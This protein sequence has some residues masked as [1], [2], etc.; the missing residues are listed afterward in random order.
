MLPSPANVAHSPVNM[1]ASPANVSHSAACWACSAPYIACS[2]FNWVLAEACMEGSP[3]I[4]ADAVSFSVHRQGNKTPSS[5]QLNAYSV[6]LSAEAGN[7]GKYLP[8]Q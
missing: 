6:F 8:L 7:V 3:A 1:V 4:M 2:L 5:T